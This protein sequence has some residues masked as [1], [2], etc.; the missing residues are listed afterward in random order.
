MRHRGMHEPLL[1]IGGERKNNLPRVSEELE[2]LEGLDCDV[3]NAAWV[4][5]D[6][7]MCE[8]SICNLKGL[9]SWMLAPGRQ[10]NASQQ[11]K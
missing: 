7:E 2:R 9:E 4:M 11:R 8:R 1:L 3:N 6:P 10:P 5:L